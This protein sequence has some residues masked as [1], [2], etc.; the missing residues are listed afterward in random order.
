VQV[1]KS[2]LQ[3]FLSLLSDTQ[4]SH[5]QREDFWGKHGVKLFQGWFI[6]GGDTLEQLGFS[7]PSLQFKRRGA[8]SI[9]CTAHLESEGLSMQVKG[10]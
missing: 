10:L 3:H 9:G 8:G 4:H 2:I 7:H 5:G 1:D 6:P